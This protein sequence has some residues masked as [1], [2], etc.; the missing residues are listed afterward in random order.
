LVIFFLPKSNNFLPNINEF[1]TK[2]L[3][4]IK[5]HQIYSKFCNGNQLV[6]VHIILVHFIYRVQT[7]SRFSWTR[8]FIVEK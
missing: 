6:T 7:F 1:L 2:T 8:V 4:F 5:K 3:F